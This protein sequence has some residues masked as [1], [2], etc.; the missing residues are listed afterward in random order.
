MMPRQALVA[1]RSDADTLPR[2]ARPRHA[3]N[4]VFRRITRVMMNH[5][6]FVTA[7]F[8]DIGSEC[9]EREG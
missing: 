2:R 9:R 7:F 1:P 5:E 4:E 3:L 6:P 8:V